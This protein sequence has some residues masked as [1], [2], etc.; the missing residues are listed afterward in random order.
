MATLQQAFI[1]RHWEYMQ[2]QRGSYGD[3]HAFKRV[4]PVTEWKREI[5]RWRENDARREDI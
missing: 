5:N 4:Q 1:F 3:Q 2:L